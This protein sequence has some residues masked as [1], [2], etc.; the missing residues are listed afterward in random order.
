MRDCGRGVGLLS[1][2]APAQRDALVRALAKDDVHLCGHL[3]T[4]GLATE[5]APGQFTDKFRN[6]VMFPIH[7]RRGQVIG[8]GGRVL[9][10]RQPKYLN[11]P[12]TPLFHKGRELYG[13]WQARQANRK[14][15]KV[16]VVE[17]YM[18]VVALAQHD[19]TDTVAS[20]GTAATSEHVEK[21]FQT[22]NHIVFCFDGDRAGLQ[23]A[24]RALENSL[25]HMRGGRQIGF[26]FLPEGEDPDTL[27]R[28]A[29][30]DA[31]HERV[32]TATPLSDYL[33]QELSLAHPPETMEGRSALAEAAK[34]LLAKLPPGV[35]H[36]LALQRLAELTRLAVERLGLKAPQVPARHSQSTPTPMGPKQAASKAHQKAP[37]PSLMRRVLTLLIHHPSLAQGIE[38]RPMLDKLTQ[39][40]ADLLREALDL[41][42][43]RPDLTTGGLLEHFRD[44]AHGK[45]LTRLASGPAPLI[46][47]GLELEF[48]DALKKLLQ[49]RA[50]E[51]FRTLTERAR[52][53]DLTS[54]EKDEYQQL[55][56]GQKN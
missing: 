8:F 17:G 2:F 39:P 36:E 6:R 7:N 33:F 51:R 10:D 28:A 1:D 46:E 42:A 45:H 49:L 54:A 13:L 31:I 50:E 53:S 21:L 19:I 12:E 25:P 27:V 47:A 48:S 20:L 37:T 43:S 34:P 15:S 24:W 26:I 38:F 5:R 56:A 30:A 14:L 23:A 16:I 41:G 44:H 9:D 52:Q 35:F 11:S 55:L 22:T 4:A 3:V 29:G 40:G 18:D 32:L